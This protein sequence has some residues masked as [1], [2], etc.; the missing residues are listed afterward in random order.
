MNECPICHVYFKSL[1]QHIAK[2]S[3]C[4]DIL[5][6]GRIGGHQTLHANVESTTK[7]N[8]SPRNV[9][10]N[11]YDNLD[12]NDQ[13]YYNDDIYSTG[14]NQSGGRAVEESV[15][16]VDDH[17]DNQSIS[18][19][20]PHETAA[21]IEQLPSKYF[22]TPNFVLPPQ[23]RGHIELLYFADKYAIPKRGW[24]D[25]CKLLNNLH[26][27]KFDFA[28]K[29]P[30]RDQIV[31]S[32][33]NQFPTPPLESVRVLLEKDRVD[34]LKPTGKKKPMKFRDKPQMVSVFRFEIQHQIK[35]LLSEPLFHNAS[36]LVVNEQDPFGKYIPPNGV[37]DE[38]QSGAWY[39]RTYDKILASHNDSEELPAMVL[40]LKIYCDKTG[41]DP[42]M[43]RHSL[44]PVMFSFTIINR[45]MQNECD[46]SW[47]HIGFI[48]DLDKY[49]K[50]EKKFSAGKGRKGRPTRNYHRCWEA[51]L[52]PLIQLQKEGLTVFMRI[53]NLLRKVKAYFPV[54]II[55]G[56]AKS[57]D[58]LC[59]RVAHYNQARMS[60]ACYT[61]FEDCNSY[62][63]QCS[64]VCQDEQ[65]LLL[66]HCMEPGASDNE[67]LEMALREVSTVRCYS[68]L[69]SMDFGDNPN[70]Q[71]LACTVDPMHMFESGWCAM[72]CKAFVKDMS[73]S[74]CSELDAFLLEIMRRARSSRRNR[75]P[76]TNF[77]GGITG[78]TNIASHE[79]VGIL[80]CYNV[81]TQSET[82]FQIIKS[83]FSDTESSYQQKQQR[84][85]IRNKNHAKRQRLLAEHGLLTRGEM[86]R[87]RSN[88]NDDEENSSDGD[89]SEGES[90]ADEK[91]EEDLNNCTSSDSSSD[92]EVRC[93]RIKFIELC[94][95]MMCFHAY[96]KKGEYWACGDELSA[97]VFDKAIRGMMRQL[98]STLER[99][100]G[101]YNWNI[102]K[103]HEILHLVKQ[104][105]EYGNISNTD[106]GVGERGLKLWAKRHGRRARKASDEIFVHSTANMVKELT[107]ITQAHQSLNP[108]LYS[109]CSSPNNQIDRVQMNNRDVG[110]DTSCTLCGKP[111]YIIRW[112][113]S[114]DDETGTIYCDW[115][116]SYDY[117]GTVELP[118]GI[119]DLY[120]AEFF[121]ESDHLH[122]V[123]INGYTEMI[124]R[125]GERCRAHPNYRS[126]GSIYDWVIAEEPDEYANFIGKSDV[127]SRLGERYPNHVPCRL[128]AL[129]LHPHSKKPVA[130]VHMCLPYSTKNYD[131]SSVLIEHWTLDGNVV[132]QY[133][134]S[135]GQLHQQR[136]KG[137]SRVTRYI[138]R[139]RVI[140]IDKIKEGLM[141]IQE[142]ELL[143]DSWK[144][145]PRV[146]NVMV[147]LDRDEYWAQEFIMYE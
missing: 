66:E 32:L 94:E 140:S 92:L 25:L 41:V 133:E 116:S 53:G 126:E 71:Y 35:S 76:R 121:S 16:Q 7:D 59:C 9:E 139:Y 64:W 10:N 79:W 120:E 78:L 77:S 106:T 102:Q 5:T 128:L 123:S 1:A 142:N 19:L 4:R 95:M 6:T 40:P 43:Q 51:L 3:F 99:G 141:V 42:M 145:S 122:S 101:T 91:D 37:L 81:A 124:T 69:F 112:E 46:K 74:V 83:R 130:F 119:M 87:N 107:L 22:T 50:A 98:L 14:G 20:P 47:R 33:H 111:K 30:S 27:M 61:S 68:S 8:K 85:K 137:A 52:D 49:S 45:K 138:P 24:E 114:E 2:T 117:K 63:K 88:Q 89:V 146:G 84:K 143:A 67:D 115:Q 96:Y 125:L 129:F 82:G 21:D 127:P 72:V 55:M 108:H 65:K 26:E 31:S 13:Q 36:N 54:A 57:N 39:S 75:F 93:T 103:F 86:L 109:N 113:A 105:E 44:E 118:D 17:I 131:C 135:D 12:E 56:D 62:R 97:G 134:T 90:T 34:S 147:I 15:E 48:P 104:V 100:E 144:Y 11:Q 23:I 110:A 28:E 60:R 18:D 29:H 80:L 132:H 70:G 136:Q 58:M 73:V 38:I